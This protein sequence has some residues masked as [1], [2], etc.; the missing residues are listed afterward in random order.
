MCQLNKLVTLHNCWLVRFITVS[1]TEAFAALDHT[2]TFN[3]SF[4]GCHVAFMVQVNF[5]RDLTCWVYRILQGS[6]VIFS[7]NII[8]I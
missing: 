2:C 7:Y 8:A 5:C 1:S 4:V 3:S 6:L